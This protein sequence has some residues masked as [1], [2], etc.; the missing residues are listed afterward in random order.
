MTLP[1]R[2]SDLYT[3]DEFYDLVSEGQKADLIEG[4]IYL[5]SPD[6]R[7]NDDLNTF[8]LFLMSGFADAR[9]LGHV[10]GSRYAYRLGD[11]RAP[12]PDAAFVR[13]DRV[14]E[15]VTEREGMGPPDVAVEVVARDSRTRDYHDKLHLYEAAGVR[16]YWLLDPMIGRAEFRRLVDG[17]YELVP[18]EENRIF[19]SEALPGFWIDVDWLFG[20]RRPGKMDCLARLLANPRPPSSHTA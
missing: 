16:E 14:G 4:V 10:S 19:R 2:D 20:T 13:S 5:A 18:L 17:C 6:T 1:A 9:G 15:V 3:V 11:R 12:E 7:R 8:M